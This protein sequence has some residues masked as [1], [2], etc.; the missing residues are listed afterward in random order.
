MKTIYVKGNII[1]TIGKFRYSSKSG[2]RFDESYID[3]ADEVIDGDL[4]I[5]PASKDQG[6]IYNT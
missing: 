1:Y 5:G 2:A 6:S 3:K 4:V